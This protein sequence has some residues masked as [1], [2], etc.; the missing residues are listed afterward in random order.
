MFYFCEMIKETSIQDPELGVI[1]LR[2]N[3][4]A[5]HYSLHVTNDRRIIA[6]V[7]KTG[8][9]PEVLRFVEQVRTKLR[10]MLAT[11]S[12]KQMLCETTELQ[13]TTFRVHI[14]R[15]ERNNFYMN[16][17][18]GILHIACPAE[19]CFE[20]E[21]VQHLLKGMVEKALRYEAN[22]LLPHRL[23]ELA[24]KHHFAY[25]EVKITKS[26][27]RWGS[28]SARK[29]INLSCF[30]MLLPW[31]LIDYVLLHELCHTVE[32]NHSESFWKLMNQVCDGKALA[33]RQELKTHRML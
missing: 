9:L 30:L 8:S 14:F 13:T 18:E 28:C 6:T 25:S 17:H 22:R 2:F 26:K 19:T 7:P 11:C 32:L 10:K 23:M 27:S 21:A 4:R 5:I 1:T 24:Q 15:T 31:H 33:L 12:P 29:S 20:D 16:L 3:S